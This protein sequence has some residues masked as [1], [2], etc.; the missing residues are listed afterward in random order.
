[1]LEKYEQAL[2]HWLADIVANGDDDAL[3]A[4]GYLQGHFAV[5]LAELE[6]ESEQGTEALAIKMQHCLKQAAKELED[7]DY[8]LVEHAWLELQRRIDD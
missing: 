7:P 6:A 2:E 4:S 3:F 1:M 8:R 5:V